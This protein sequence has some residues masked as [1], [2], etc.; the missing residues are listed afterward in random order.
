MVELPS[1]TTVPSSPGIDQQVA[2]DIANIQAT[3][4]EGGLTEP[5]TSIVR[6]RLDNRLSLLRASVRQAAV[7]EIESEVAKLMTGYPSQRTVSKADAMLMARE[8]SEALRGVPIWAVALACKDISRGSIPELNPDFPPSAP[9][10][11]Q[12]VDEYVSPVHVE[13]RSIK[14]VLN[15]PSALPDNPEIAERIKLKFAQ[16]SEELHANNDM[17]RAP[18]PTP[19]KAPTPAEIKAHYDAHGLAFEPKARRMDDLRDD[20]AAA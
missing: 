8:Y 15:A 12:I 7:D 20:G 19:W 4:R 14:A 1:T 11:R 3:M 17:E 16:L 5:I 10:L 13:A 6:G 18:N 9:R 2:R